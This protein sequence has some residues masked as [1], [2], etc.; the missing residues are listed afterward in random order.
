VLFIGAVA[1]VVSVLLVYLVEELLLLWYMWRSDIA[2]RAELSEDY[3]F[4]MLCV[5]FGVVA[6]A[7]IFPTT[8]YF[9]RRLFKLGKWG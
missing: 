3:G 9:L 8:C 7:V 2:A 1:L 4:G 6:F 5:A